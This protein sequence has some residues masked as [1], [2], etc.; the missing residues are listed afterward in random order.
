MP[1]RPA[2]AYPAPMRAFALA[3]LF[4]CAVPAW[5]KEQVVI[6]VYTGW[7]TP[8]RVEVSGRVLRAE[9]G[10]AG[11]PAK[12]QGALENLIANISALE[13]DEVEESA[14]TVTL[15]AAVQQ[16]KADEEGLFRAVFEKLDPPLAPGLQEIAV[17]ATDP[18]HGLPA[19][20]ASGE[21][22][23][24][25]PGCRYAIVS[26]IDDTIVQSIVTQKMVLLANT[27]LKNA[28]SATP[29]PGKAKLYQLLAEG[30]PPP[31][32]FYVSGSPV[33][34]YPRLAYYLAL[35]GFPPGPVILKN[36]GLH[37]E[38]DALFEQIAYK[39]AKIEPLLAAFPDLTFLCFGDSGEKDPEIYGALA[40]K[41][42]GRIRHI[43]IRLV[44]DEK[45]D[46]PRFAGMSAGKD[47]FAEARALVAAGLLTEAQALETAQDALGGKPLPAGFTLASELP[48][49]P[50][51][52][53][54][55]VEAGDIWDNFFRFLAQN[56][57][58]W[59]KMI[60][61][62]L[63]HMIGFGLLGGCAGGVL[64]LLLYWKVRGWGWTANR[65][66]WYRWVGWLMPFWFVFTLSLG[67][68][69]GGVYVG[70][71]R[72]VEH[73]ILHER[74]V[75][76]TLIQLAVTILAT[77]EEHAK[78][79]DLA[80]KADEMAARATAIEAE[81]DR[82]VEKEVDEKVGD[83]VSG[84]PGGGILERWVVSLLG[85]LT[86]EALQGKPE[87]KVLR[88]AAL[89]SDEEL[90]KQLEGSPEQAVAAGYAALRPV[91][92]KLD[93]TLAG[94]VSSFVWTSAAVFGLGGLVLT[95]LPVG[96]V[97]LFDRW[98]YGK[99]GG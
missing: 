82:K 29:V 64:A 99:R 75:Q 39:T 46:A 37:H 81:L 90:T 88:S 86:V 35:H 42:P 27:F 7:G 55:T 36:L 71:G 13:S 49:A 28:A 23:V 11:K 16:V 20:R 91:L 30:A 10:D 92:E 59:L 47:S 74:V 40:K 34:L 14:V 66:R 41:F 8:T 43:S 58:A 87:Y 3:L 2:Q 21:V 72:R 52:A 56:W 5:A 57:A 17:T 96:V 1:S 38:H 19:G 78:L 89:L 80:A 65:F 97:R 9:P 53:T 95:L 70:G 26:D 83:Y 22:F 62:V 63:L 4:A 24:V 48:A 94:Y 31:P 44:T 50:E 25:G 18:K 77:R 68:G 98:V 45:A 6:H 69:A 32:V 73:L 76:R 12:G 51:T 54:W 67:L 60:G 93:D 79:G 61:T 85:R 15:G 84:R 33:N